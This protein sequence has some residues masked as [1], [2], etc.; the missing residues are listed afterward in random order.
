MPVTWVETRD[1]PLADLTP[2]PGNARRGDTEA[3]RASVRRNGQYRALVVRDTGDGLVILAGNHTAQAI[4]AEGD[5]TA[6]C[7]ILKCSDDEA[8]RINL[9]DNRLAELGGY[10]DDALADLLRG[11]DGDL[12]GTGWSDSDVSRMLDMELPDGFAT[13]DESVADD[14]SEPD[15]GTTHIC[16]ACGHSFTETR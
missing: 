11:L 10:D 14:L 9:A 13:F 2:F 15:G 12:D 16:P 7:E 3:I 4:E 5:A 6:R 1:I 8:L